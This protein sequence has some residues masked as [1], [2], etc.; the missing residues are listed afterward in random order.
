EPRQIAHAAPPGLQTAALTAATTRDPKNSAEHRSRNARFR[1]V[2]VI[3][4]DADA[5]IGTEQ[6]AAEI[7]DRSLQVRKTNIAA[8]HETFDLVELRSVGGV[9]R[10][11]PVDG[12]RGDDP[13]GR[14]VA[15]HVPDLDR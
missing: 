9:S 3:A 12:A 7:L 13:N 1:K 15:E 8:D 5:P 10:I 14:L 11:A 4:D 2:E 6:C